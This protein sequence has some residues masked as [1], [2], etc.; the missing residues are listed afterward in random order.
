MDPEVHLDPTRPPAGK[1]E[2]FSGMT[3]TSAILQIILIV[4]VLI[5][6]T[7]H[8]YKGNLEL[9]F[10]TLPLLMLYYVFTIGRS[11]RTQPSDSDGADGP[12]DHS[13]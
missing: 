1:G 7:F 11:R 4:M 3:K 12:H 8:F 2:L 5:Y 13:G 6:S 9:A 10:S